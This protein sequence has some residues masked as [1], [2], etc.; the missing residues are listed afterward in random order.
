VPFVKAAVMV[1][2]VAAGHLVI[3]PELISMAGGP[4]GQRLPDVEGA[5]GGRRPSE[6][7]GTDAGRK[8]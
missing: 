7:A 2:D 4:A 5:E 8:E 6:A 3:D 1:V